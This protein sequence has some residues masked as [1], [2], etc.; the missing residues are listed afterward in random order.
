M[1]GASLGRWGCGLCCFATSAVGYAGFCVVRW[2]QKICDKRRHDEDGT[3]PCV[4][5]A[6]SGDTTLRRVT[7]V[8]VV[9]VN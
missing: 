7:V 5:R 9:G 2:A 1:K 6:A 8:A 4:G 3:P